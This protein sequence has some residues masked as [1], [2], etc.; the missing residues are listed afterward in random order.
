[1]VLPDFFIVGLLDTGVH[2]L[3]FYLKQID[4]RGQADGSI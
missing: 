2:M 4:A 3:N 1:M